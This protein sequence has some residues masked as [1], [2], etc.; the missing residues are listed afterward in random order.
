MK[1]PFPYSK[2]STLLQICKLEEQGMHEQNPPFPKSIDRQ[3][4]IDH[5]LDEK[6]HVLA[7]IDVVRGR[8]LGILTYQIRNH[9][10]PD[11][12]QR[13]VPD[14]EASVNSIYVLSAERRNGIATELFVAFLEKIQKLI[15]VP[16]YMY[17]VLSLEEYSDGVTMPMYESLLG[18]QFEN[19]GSFSPTYVTDNL[20]GSPFM[21]ELAPFRAHI[22]S[23]LSHLLANKK[24]QSP[25]VRIYDSYETDM[26]PS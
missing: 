4:T 3:A 19:G 14:Y 1:K 21:V 26:L 7:M 25:D 15:S 13:Y 8:V 6:L 16:A 12:R 5:I 23:A 11:L 9:I 24:P 20:D 10:P 2:Q 18:V 17:F 22:N